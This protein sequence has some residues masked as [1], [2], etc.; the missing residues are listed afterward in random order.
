MFICY[1]C[2]IHFC[3]FYYDYILN[4]FQ[5]LLQLQLTGGCFSVILPFSLQFKLTE[6][7][8][9]SGTTRQKTLDWTI[10]KQIEKR[11]ALRGESSIRRKIENG[12]LN[13]LLGREPMNTFILQNMVVDRKRDIIQQTLKCGY[14]NVHTCMIKSNINGQWLHKIQSFHEP[15]M[16]T[17]PEAN[18]H[19]VKANSYEAEA[20][21]ALILATFF[22]LTPF[23]A[24]NEIFGRFST[25]LQQFRLKTGSNM[26][27][28][29]VSTP[30]MTS[31]AFG[32]RLLLLCLHT[33]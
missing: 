30:K 10:E 9:L 33:E 15:G 14:L 17:R 16:L 4:I 3:S 29:L 1:F 28:L 13:L 7:T 19:E 32:R 22:I 18:S 21:I 20:K 2:C 31:Y 23:A 6:G 12:A 5:L 11:V 26:G 27:T 24:K 8:L 25:I